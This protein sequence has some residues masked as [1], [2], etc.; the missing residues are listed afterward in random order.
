MTEYRHTGLGHLIRHAGI[1]IRRNDGLSM[2]IEE[3]KR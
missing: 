1:G 2:K 3:I